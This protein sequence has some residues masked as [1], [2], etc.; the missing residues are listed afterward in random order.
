MDLLSNPWRQSWKC[1][2]SCQ[3]HTDST[4]KGIHINTNLNNKSAKPPGRGTPRMICISRPSRQVGEHR[5]WY[6]GVAIAVL[7]LMCIIIHLLILICI[8]IYI[9]INIYINKLRD[10]HEIICFEMFPSLSPTTQKNA[11]PWKADTFSGRL[12]RRSRAPNWSQAKRR[13]QVCTITS[14]NRKRPSGSALHEYALHVQYRH[15]WKMY[16]LIKTYLLSTINRRSRQV[17]KHRKWYV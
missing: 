4:V 14:A 3:I 11:V 2:S 6:D 17:E 16:K 10:L 7:I 12:S 1:K 5:R 9:H 15:A 13:V 8:Y